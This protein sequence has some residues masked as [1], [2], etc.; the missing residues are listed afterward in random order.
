MAAFK[1]VYDAYPR[2]LTSW[3]LSNDRSVNYREHVNI[4]TELAGADAPK[5]KFM[6]TVFFEFGGTLRNARIDTGS[7]DLERNTYACKS[8]SRP[9]IS[10]NYT[11]VNS[12]NYRFKVATRT[13]V[14]TVTLSLYDDNKNVSHNL[15][16]KYL[17]AISPVANRESGASYYNSRDDVANWSS[18]GPLPSKGSISQLG[19]ADGLIQTMRVT[20]H[21]N[22]S[23]TDDGKSHSMVHYDYINPKI[24]SF[25][26]DELDMSTSEPSSVSI[27]FVFDSVNIV[28][29]HAKVLDG[30]E[31]VQM[32]RTT[33]DV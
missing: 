17:K 22:D 16:S 2:S 26:F 30:V 7:P 11:E 3:R 24:Q 33:L 18:L 28:E 21:Y 13:D 20:H 15:L 6:F 29:D 5:F 1:P 27:T 32:P 23:Y 31:R 19:E 14:G 9:N 4:G 25:S 8:V 10:V 12:Y